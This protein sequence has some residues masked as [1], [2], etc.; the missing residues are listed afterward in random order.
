MSRGLAYALV[1]LVGLGI[2]GVDVLV[3]TSGATLTRIA[4]RELEHVFGDRLEKSAVAFTLGGGLELRGAGLWATKKRLK[5][6]SADRVRVSVARRG[7]TFAAD[8]V[9][10]DRPR[11]SL[12]DRLLEAL[13]EEP[14]SGSITD[15]VKPEQLPKVLCRGGAI[16]IAHADVLDW[17][18]PLVLDIEEVQ[19]VPVTGYRYFLGGRLRSRLLGEWRASGEIDL[20]TGAHDVT[21]TGENV[22]LGP[23]VRAMLS[24]KVHPE[25]DRYSPGGRARM[26]IRTWRDPGP[27]SAPQFVLTVQALDM[28]LCYQPFPYAWERVT[29]EIDFHEDYF[30]VKHLTGESGA[31]RVWFDGRCE[32]YGAEAPYTFRLEVKSMGL[33]GKL[34]AAVGDEVRKVWDEFSPRGTL[35]AH[36]TIT[37]EAGPDKPTLHPL[38]ITFKDAFFRYRPFPYELEQASGEI[39]VEGEDVTV[40]FF[41]ARRGPAAMTASGTI[42]G[43]G[44]DTAVDLRIRGRDVPLDGHLKQA[45]GASL[46][47][48]WD[49]FEATGSVDVD[50]H[51][52]KE[53]RAE[54]A[55]FGTIRAKGN[56]VKYRQVPLPVTDVTGEVEVAP[57]V[58]EMHHLEGKLDNGEVAI[59]GTWRDLGKGYDL[60]L[61]VDSRGAV[62]DDRFKAAMPASI[63]KVLKSLRTSGVADYSFTMDMREGDKPKLNWALDCRV[64]KG[65]IDTQVRVDDMEGDITLNGVIE[66]D[67]LAAFG[68]LH[69]QQARFMGKKVT[70]ITSP[71]VVNGT[72]VTF[73]NLRGKAYRGDATGIF[74][75]DSE[76][77]EL[78]GEF[79][80][81]RLEL[82]DFVRDSPKYADR[83]YRGKVNIVISDLKGFGTDAASLTGKGSMLITE[84]QLFEVPGIVNILTLKSGGRFKAARAD[85]TIRDRKFYVEEP[86]LLVFEAETG[87]VY[88][89]GWVDFDLK[90]KFKVTSETAPLLGIDFWLFRIP[91]IL[92]D[93]T[94]SPF[95]KTVKGTIGESAEEGPVDDK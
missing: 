86:N 94:K 13:A 27:G 17:S 85:F 30:V 89:R 60:H 8:A 2:V 69:F 66:K 34:Y 64:T 22:M 19:M 49:E 26:R 31:A 55:H 92:F 71:C 48:L 93:F 54:E 16:E 28:T 90:Y 84:G 35:D 3:L 80:V 21:L 70:D 7:G 75:I 63:A 40:K 6:F 36:S 4:A 77:A 68:F 50:W 39:R 12:S 53:A 29:G 38:D 73:S 47:K 9:E 81:D 14:P 87:S 44:G 65:V 41:T 59:N 11:F 25:Y 67:L 43:T 83:N 82:R 24:P 62:I 46:K 5:V 61:T 95:R 45:M 88:G 78:G 91:S 10:L 20:E 32:G 56:R 58:V 23:A 52:V 42:R 72:K 76:T 79:T 51:V 15:H 1:V 18:T 74:W 57:G 37:R 33:D